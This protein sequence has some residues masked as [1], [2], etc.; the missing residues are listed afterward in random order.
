MTTAE[1]FAAAM[2]SDEPLHPALVP[3]LEESDVLGQVLKHPLVFSVPYF[4]A[5][6]A[7]LQYAAKQAALEAAIDSCDWST[8]I[9]LHERPYR[10]NALWQHSDEIEGKVF[11]ELASR[12]WIDSENIWQNDWTWRSIF[13]LDKEG[14]EHFMDEEERA[15]F[16]ALPD[17]V[18]AYRGYAEGVNEEGMSWTT[19]PDIAKFFA[20]RFGDGLIATG[21]IAK[22][23]IFAL[24]LG[25]GE[26]ELIVP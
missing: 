25:R 4:S 17:V 2:T 9:W 24:Q 18:H 19:D 21:L 11:W 14:R 1:E 15:A 20:N 22:D 3:Y 6:M 16:D 13:R 5:G 10:V 12:V 23:E 26:N 7:N 8:I